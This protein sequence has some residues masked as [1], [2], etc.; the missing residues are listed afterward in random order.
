MQKLDLAYKCFGAWLSE[1]SFGTFRFDMKPAKILYSKLRSQ[2]SARS[3]TGSKPPWNSCAG[4]GGTLAK[5]TIKESALSNGKLIV[6]LTAGVKIRI[7]FHTICTWGQLRGHY[8]SIAVST[9]ARGT[10]THVASNY[11]FSSCE[12]NVLRTLRIRKS[13][14]SHRFPMLPIMLSR[15]PTKYTSWVSLARR[16]KQL[17]TQMHSGFCDLNITRKENQTRTQSGS[18]T[19]WHCAEQDDKLKSNKSQLS[20]MQVL[21]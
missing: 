14:I 16:T 2:E 9:L 6:M 1:E 21:S 4:A 15:P 8:Q 19:L 20:N 13:M 3:S 10:F 18:K 5:P 11:L 12:T 17:L 7:W